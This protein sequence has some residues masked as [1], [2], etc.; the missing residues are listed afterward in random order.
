MPESIELSVGEM[1][2]TDAFKFM[3]DKGVS[4][5][6]AAAIVGELIHEYYGGAARTFTY[7]EEFAEVDSS[8]THKGKR[9]FHHEDWTD[10]ESVVQAEETAGEEGFNRRFHRI[11][12]DIDRLDGGLTEA[13]QCMASMRKLL[14]T[15]LEEIR[16]EV[17][18]IDD[19]IYRLGQGV[20]TDE[21]PPYSVHP[22]DFRPYEPYSNKY[23]GRTTFGK[24]IVDV[25]KTDRG[26]MVV[27]TVPVT[28][29][30]PVEE[31]RVKRVTGLARYLVEDEAVREAFTGKTVTKKELVERFGNVRT[32][33]GS[34]VAQLAEILPEAGRYR[35]LD[36]VVDAVAER[37]AAALRTTGSAGKLIAASMGVAPGQTVA[38]AG[39]DK[40]TDIPAEARA[41]LIQ[42][43]IN[44]VGKLATANLSDVTHLLAEEGVR[45]V[46]FGDVA[47]WS[48]TAK[49][50]AK[51]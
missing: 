9:I 48:A 8:C 5:P 31:E 11:E 42:R 19:D 37:E 16:V 36:Q 28:G 47:E 18:R 13:F 26:L 23:V 40:M 24:E 49:T 17:N 33:G 41:A 21:G 7:S 2:A 34:T 1:S 12:A 46:S 32:K 50:Y 45:G 39:V 30:G 10:G 22:P 29:P 20:D 44:T 15:L 43:G 38:Q 4:Q 6:E 25:F 51:L 35:T 3:V 14:H 27:P